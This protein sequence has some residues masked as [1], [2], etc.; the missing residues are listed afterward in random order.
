MAHY[1]YII[2]SLKDGTFYK[3]YS[4]QPLRRLEQHNNGDSQFTSAKIPWKL[5]YVEELPSK[6]E[7]LIREKNLKKASTERLEALLT[8]Q[9]NIV[10]QFL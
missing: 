5:I 10:A 7:A 2:E 8:H 9:K 3:G 4:T 6:T 1:V